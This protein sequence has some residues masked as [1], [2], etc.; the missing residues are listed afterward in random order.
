MEKEEPQE[1]QIDYCKLDEI[2]EKKAT[3]Y[4][5]FWFLSIISLANE[6]KQLKIQYK[7][8]V[9]RMAAMAWPMIF[10]DEINLGKIDMMTKYLSSVEKSTKLIPAAT[11]KVVENYLTQHYQSQGVDR[12]LSPLLKNVPYRFLSPWVKYTTDEDVV[13]VS[14]RRDFAGL[15]ALEEEGIALNE[16]WWNYI[17]ENYRDICKQTMES[18]ETYLKDYNSGMALVKLKFSGI[19]FIG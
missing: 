5:Y 8:I 6:R 4:K 10:E 9:I 13:T 3:S 16:T 1:L 2:F 15:Y 12:I 18:F 7:D 17:K 14:N 11:S 19:P